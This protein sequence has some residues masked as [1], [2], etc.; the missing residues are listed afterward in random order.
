MNIILLVLFYIMSEPFQTGWSNGKVLI[1]GP[2]ITYTKEKIYSTSIFEEGGVKSSVTDSYPISDKKKLT[3]QV[4][5]DEPG[6]TFPVKLK[7]KLDNEKAEYG[8]VAKLLVISDIESNF[9]AFRTLLQVNGVIDEN[10]NWIYGRGHLTLTG[11]FFDRGNQQNEVL[12]LIYSLE[13]QAKA[14]KGYVHFILGNHEIMNMSGDFR[15]VNPRYM[16]HAKLMNEPY[17][18][19]YWDDT[20]LGRWLRTK[21][22]AEKI[23]DILFVHGGISALVNLMGMPAPQINDIARPF[24]PDTA[25]NYPDIKVEILFSDLGPFWYRGYYSQKAKATSKQIDSTLSLFNV[26]YIATGHTVIADTISVLF[27]GRVF[28]TDVYHAKGISEAMLV[29]EGKFY[30]VN[31]LGEK[32]LLK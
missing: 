20:E 23:S 24:Y 31:S 9:K 22:I 13:E 29:E 1:D 26:K 18:S 32:K 15:Y 3:L 10:F 7:A 17:I 5:T 4:A 8:K 21:N 11:D 30:R 2:Y 25:Y 16:E 14:A 12:W 27:D 6:K 28:N 19:L